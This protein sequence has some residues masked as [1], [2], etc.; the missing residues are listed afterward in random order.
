ML[1]GIQGERD[2]WE[3]PEKGRLTLV[4]EDQVRE[5]L[6]RLNTH[7]SVGPDGMHLQ[8]LRELADTIATLTWTQFWVTC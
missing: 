1:S 8:V 3:S 4:D 7:K 5:H 6:N 2:S